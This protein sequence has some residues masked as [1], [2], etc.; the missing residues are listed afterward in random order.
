MIMNDVHK[1]MIY[2]QEHIISYHMRRGEE[3]VRERERTIIVLTFYF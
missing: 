3:R 2:Q 1:E